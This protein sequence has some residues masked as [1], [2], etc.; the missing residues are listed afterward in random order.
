MYISPRLKIISNFILSIFYFLIIFRLFR[1]K[2]Q[3]H[4]KKLTNSQCN[5]E[6]ENFIQAYLRIRTQE[7][8]CQK[9]VLKRLRRRSVYV[10]FGSRGTCSQTHILVEGY[11]YLKGTDN[12]VNSFSALLSTGRGKKLGSWKC[13][14]EISNY[15]RVSSFSSQSTKRLI[16][17][18]T[19]DSFPGVLYCRSTTA[20]TNDLILVELEGGPHSL[21]YNPFPFGL[22]FVQGFGK[23]FMANWSHDA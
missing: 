12:L 5:K 9:T 8:V 4:W 3:C 10:W 13:L 21:F 19:L 14:L 22:N 20:M 17:T 2:S 23:W 16:L 11:C 6:M 1:N 18:F 7:T 15:L